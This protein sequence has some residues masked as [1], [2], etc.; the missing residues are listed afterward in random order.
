MR[1][2]IYCINEVRLDSHMVMMTVI[3]VVYKVELDS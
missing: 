3:V 2:D 1:V